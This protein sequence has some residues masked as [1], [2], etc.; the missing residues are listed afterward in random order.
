MSAYNISRTDVTVVDFAA[1]MFTVGFGDASDNS[2]IVVAA[3]AAITAVAGNG[4]IALV[5]GPASL[6][7]AIVIAHGIVHNYA[8]V[9][10]FDPKMSAYIVA[11]SHG[12]DM[13][14]GDI[15]PAS[16]VVA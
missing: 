3:N 7:A 8:V 4:T 12:S 14:I 15:I 1:H 9:A 10:V 2:G 6:P 5:N 11:S 16:N 13:K